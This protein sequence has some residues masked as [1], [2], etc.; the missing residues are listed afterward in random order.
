VKRRP[1]AVY[2]FIMVALISC[3][4]NAV[5]GPLPTTLHIT[6]P[7]I[8]GF[9]PFDRVSHDASALQQLYRM[10]YT[11]PAPSAKVNCP[12]QDALVYHLVF[13]RGTTIV[14]EMTLQA[15]GC[16]FLNFDQETRMTNPVFIRLFL[17]LAGIS[18]LVPPRTD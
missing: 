10:A 13:L 5:Q 7:A 2:V 18:S 3:T 12:M 11:L 15:T 8:N 9:P 6:R 16:Q 1:V 14:K 4:S 17:H